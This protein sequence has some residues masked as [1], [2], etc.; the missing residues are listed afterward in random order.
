[1]DRKRYIEYLNETS[2]MV[3]PFIKASMEKAVLGVPELENHLFYLFKYREDRPLLKPTLFRLA[4]ESCGGKEFETYLPFAAACE[5]LNISS[6]QANSSFDNKLG[7]LSN[8]DKDGQVM[9]AMITRELAARLVYQ[10]SDGR[11]IGEKKLKELAECISTSNLFI[12]KAQHYDLNVLSFSNRK[13]F[14]CYIQDRELY[15]RDYHKRCYFGSGVFSG[16]VALA[17]AIAADADNAHRDA[18]MKFGEIYGTALHKIN[19]L[20]DFL[21][22]EE[23]HGRI[24][25]DFFCDIRNGRLT[26]PVYELYTKFPNIYTDIMNILNED[27]PNYDEIHTLFISLAIVDGVKKEAKNSYIAAKKV[28]KDIP[29]YSSKSGLLSMLSVLK[30]NK[31]YH[32]AYNKQP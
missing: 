23:R 12:Y 10:I 9:A 14:E 6:Y 29:L 15:L 30:S 25:Q 16:Q 27:R 17:G 8:E 32:R 19:D 3:M 26:W 20:G 5:L 24:Y 18:L 7:V 13:M 1:M 21:P 2:R 22:G 31:Y 28:V 11:F 4:Y